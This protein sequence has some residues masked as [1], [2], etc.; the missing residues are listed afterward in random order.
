[1]LARRGVLPDDFRAYILRIDAHEDASDLADA[2]DSARSGIPDAYESVE[3]DADRRE[4][5]EAASEVDAP[6]E[7]VTALWYPVP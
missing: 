3:G 1:M 4:L 7:G 5:V 6:Q 2:Y